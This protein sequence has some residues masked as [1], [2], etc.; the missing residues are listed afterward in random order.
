MVNIM[1]G[2]AVVPELI[3]GDFTVAGVVKE[4]QNL[5]ENQDLRDRITGK[6]AALKEKLGAPGA[7]HRVAAIA[8]S[9]IG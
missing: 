8:L 9:M 3:Q 5:L 6:L 1:A 4:T 7:A 2:E